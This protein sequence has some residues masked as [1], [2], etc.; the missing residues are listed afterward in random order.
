VGLLYK[1]QTFVLFEKHLSQGDQYS[2]I[3]LRLVAALEL[4][5]HEKRGVQELPCWPLEEQQE[6]LGRQGLFP[7]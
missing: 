7:V 5:F 4:L 3:L 2:E 1:Y 6:V